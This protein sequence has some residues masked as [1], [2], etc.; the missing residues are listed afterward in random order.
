[1]NCGH[2]IC[3]Y[4]EQVPAENPEQDRDIVKKEGGVRWRENLGKYVAEY[5]PPRFKWKLWMG[6]YI[7]VDEARRACDCARFYAGQGEGGFYFTD[8][9]ALFAELGPLNRPVTLVSKESKDKAFNIELKKRAK[10]IIRKVKN[11]QIFSDSVPSTS[12]QQLKPS[13]LD[14]IESFDPSE[15]DSQAQLWDESKGSSSQSWSFYASQV[16]QEH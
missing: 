1:M 7:S 6:T 9:P 11:V 10:E 13:P 4:R 2:G 16:D 5:R 14:P 3:D 8:S 12:N 15:I